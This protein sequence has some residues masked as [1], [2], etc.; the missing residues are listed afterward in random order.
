MPPALQARRR[1]AVRAL[2]VSLARDVVFAAGARRLARSADR[3]GR[4]ARAVDALHRVP[5]PEG[6]P[7]FLT[8]HREPAA[9]VRAALL[10][11]LLT[12]AGE[13]ARVEY[14]REATLVRV[15]VAFADVARLPPHAL[16]FACGRDAWDLV[17][18]PGAAS[19]AYVP[20]LLRDALRRRR[21]AR[22]VAA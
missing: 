12:A 22:L 13:R 14:T 4:I 2:V 19:F 21:R 16:L 17:L 5:V 18:V 6:P 1:A 15:A 9:D 3:V 8:A 11:A 10:A 20:P 7:R